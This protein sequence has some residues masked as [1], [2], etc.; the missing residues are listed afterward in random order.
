MN[1]VKELLNNMINNK[2]WYEGED[3]TDLL[4]EFGDCSSGYICDIISQ[5]A[6]NNVDIYNYDLWE[7][8]KDNENYIEEAI[9]NF[10]IDS[11]NFNLIKLFQM[12]QYQFYEQAIYSNLSDFIYYTIL[13][14]INVEEIS[15]NVLE[16]IENIS[17]KEDNNED[18]EIYI[19]KINNMIEM[20]A[21]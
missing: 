5:V 10:G 1:N 16:E 8:A 6:D 18:I 2:I 15:D 4:E 17:N 20:E 3:I 12:G 9:A 21:C 11:K 13:N 14:N 7:W 19:E